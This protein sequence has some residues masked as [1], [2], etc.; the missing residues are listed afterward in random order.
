MAPDT[1]S[2][3]YALIEPA[4]AEVLR[5]YTNPSVKLGLQA[6]MLNP[7]ARDATKANVSRPY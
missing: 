7:R 1:L 4:G 6:V 2:I 5:A 3:V